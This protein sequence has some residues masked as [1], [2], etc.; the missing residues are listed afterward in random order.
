MQYHV[1]KGQSASSS[2]QNVVSGNDP[3]YN[4]SGFITFDDTCSL[5]G[6]ACWDANG[7]VRDPGKWEGWYLTQPQLFYAASFWRN[8]GRT[9]PAAS[10]DNDLEQPLPTS[11]TTGD[12]YGTY[13]DTTFPNHTYTSAI[14]NFGV[15]ANI[16]AETVSSLPAAPAATDVEL[17]SQHWNNLSD[18]M[19]YN[20]VN[21]STYS[22]VDFDALFG[23]A[24]E[25]QQIL[26]KTAA[27]NVAIRVSTT[28]AGNELSLIERPTDYQN[29]ALVLCDDTNRS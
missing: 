28:D 15:G 6:G 20:W 23:S 29:G 8:T 27:S 2:W 12:D 7:W 21:L 26:A 24:L 1:N 25:D 22:T 3:D 11:G 17:P 16:L 18:D 10:G 5:I 14:V 19:D 9:E 4:T 13:N